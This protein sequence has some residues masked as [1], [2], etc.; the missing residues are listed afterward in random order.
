MTI[1]LRYTGIYESPKDGIRGA[2][3]PG[4]IHSVKTKGEEV[5][6][7]D[8]VVSEDDAFFLNPRFSEGLSDPSAG[9]KDFFEKNNPCGF[10]VRSTKNGSMTQYIFYDFCCHFVKYLPVGF[11]KEGQ[12]VSEKHRVILQ[13]SDPPHM[14]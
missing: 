1:N 4:V 5:K 11:G 7:K 12:P 2:C 9:P 14:A 10:M 3:P 6:E 8:N 13:H